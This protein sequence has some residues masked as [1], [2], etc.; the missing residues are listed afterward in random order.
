[1]KW[2]LV[3]D[4]QN[5]FI[6][7]SLENAEAE[8]I[9][10][11]IASLIKVW[12]GNIILTFDMH[13]NNYLNTS[14][15]KHLPIEHC[16]TDDGMLPPKEISDA[17]N[18]VHYNKPEVVIDAIEKHT[19]GSLDWQSWWFS[20]NDEL[21]ICGTCTDICVISNALILKTMFP[22]VPVC[23][24]EDLCAGTTKEDHDKAV[25]VMMKCQV[26]MVSKNE[27]LEDKK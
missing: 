15:G 18:M 19:F 27:F 24:I 14:E 4:M 5:D 8:K 21:Y 16:I 2:L 22:E 25:D 1:M 6:T 12:D 7:G 20:E 26:D 23:L 13:D 17:L 9:V 10:P 3:I 11:E